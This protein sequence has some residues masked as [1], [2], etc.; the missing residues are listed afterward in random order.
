MAK[1]RKGK[2]IGQQEQLMVGAVVMGIAAF[3]FYRDVLGVSVGIGD[4]S[5]GNVHGGD[6]TFTPGTYNGIGE[7]Y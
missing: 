1:K 5:G 6:G 2:K 7:I 3:W 4:Y